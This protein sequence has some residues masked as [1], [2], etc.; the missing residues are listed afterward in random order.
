MTRWYEI[1]EAELGVAE[2]LGPADNPR[3]REYFA[4]A[5]HPEV[6]RDS[7]PWC[8]AFAGWCLAQAD[9]QPSG[10]LAA[11][12]YLR[13]GKPLAMP[14]EGCIVVLRRGADPAAGHVG[15]YA[16]EANGRVMVLGGNQGDKVSV[17]AF[18]AEDVLAY[19]WPEEAALPTPDTAEHKAVHEQLKDVSWSYN[20]KSWL[21]KLVGGGSLIGAGSM[22][23]WH[24]KPIDVALIL[25]GA[26]LAAI[27]ALEVMRYRQ[28]AKAVGGKKWGF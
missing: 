15:F 2:A 26:A 5:G 17:A 25:L 22:P 18:R 12:S 10:S 6:M 21:T 20:L 11:R 19:R 24:P 4:G 27:I 23:H 3:I 9:V 8:A 16:G 13:W 1:A 28:R 7:V 14:R